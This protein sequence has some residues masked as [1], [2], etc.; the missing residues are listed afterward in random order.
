MNIFEALRK[1]AH[2]GDEFEPVPATEPTQTRVGTEE[3]IEV[4]AKRLKA[5]ESLWHEDDLTVEAKPIHHWRGMFADNGIQVTFATRKN[6]I[7][8]KYA[9]ASS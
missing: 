7:A 2:A 9:A 1:N 4:Y 3:R 6:S 5:G 8:Y